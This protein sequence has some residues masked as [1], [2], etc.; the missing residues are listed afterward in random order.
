VQAHEVRKVHFNF[1]AK[2]NGEDHNDQRPRIPIKFFLY[3]N[4]F[5]YFFRFKR[6][7]ETLPKTWECEPHAIIRLNFSKTDL[8]DI[9]RSVKNQIIDSLYPLEKR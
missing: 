8:N 9:E 3:I 7:E 5:M 6:D 1:S 4:K 2:K